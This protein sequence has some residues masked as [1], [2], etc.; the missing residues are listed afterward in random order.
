MAMTDG[1]AASFDFSFKIAV[2]RVLK[3]A[4]EEYNKSKEFTEAILLKLR[5]IFGP[6]FERALELFEANKVTAYKFESTRHSD[7]NTERVECCFYEVQGH[8]TE[9][10]TIFSSVNYC[11]CLAFEIN[12]LKN[13]ESFTCK[14]NQSTAKYC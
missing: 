8:S 14:H 1:E 10:Y 3:E 6:T 13:Q 4:T 11:P 7:N 2:R 5:Y 12:V 9:V